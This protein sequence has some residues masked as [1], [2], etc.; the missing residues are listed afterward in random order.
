MHEH[1]PLS[2]DPQ[3][4][5]ASASERSEKS[6]RPKAVDEKAG[7]FDQESYIGSIIGIYDRRR[8]LRDRSCSRRKR[9]IAVTQTRPDHA[10]RDIERRGHHRPNA[11]MLPAARNDNHAGGH[12]PACNARASIAPRASD[13]RGKGIIHHH[14]SCRSCGHEWI[15]VVHVRA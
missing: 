8:W 3:V 10:A 1:K 7:Q 11:S 6:R 9:E 2:A 4:V 5:Q 14:W 13:Y 15:A 12:C